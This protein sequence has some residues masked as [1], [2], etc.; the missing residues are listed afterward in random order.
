[1]ET[2]QIDIYVLLHSSDARVSAIVFDRSARKTKS[3]RVRGMVSSV[4]CP[5]KTNPAYRQHPRSLS[6][7][8]DP[9][10]AGRILV[11]SHDRLHAR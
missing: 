6:S 11:A 2:C 7:L 1:M 8:V 5:S 9:G 3:Q 4:C 10:H